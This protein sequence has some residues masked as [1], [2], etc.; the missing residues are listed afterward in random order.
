MENI[1]LESY[2][3]FKL[4]PNNSGKLYSNF[5]SNNKRSSITR[6]YYIISVENIFLTY[7]HL[8]I[9]EQCLYMLYTQNKLKNG[10][11]T[12]NIK[13]SDLAKKFKTDITKSATDTIKRLCEMQEVTI[14]I[15]V[16]DK[17]DKQMNIVE[18]IDTGVS[19]KYADLP[20]EINIRLNAEFVKLYRCAYLDKI[21]YL[22][23]FSAEQGSFVRY[24]MQH[25]LDGGIKASAI[26]DKMGVFEYIPFSRKKRFEQEISNLNF[27]YKN[28]KFQVKDGFVVQ[29]SGAK[30][31]SENQN[32][33]V[34]LFGIIYEQI[35]K[36][37]TKNIV[38]NDENLARYYERF[39]RFDKPQSFFKI[40]SNL[41]LMLNQSLHQENATIT[42]FSHFF[43]SVVCKNDN[44]FVVFLELNQKGFEYIISRR[45]NLDLW[46]IGSADYGLTPYNSEPA[47]LIN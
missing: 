42:Y 7:S 38:L 22:S 17:V 1:F 18:F 16:K 33:Q 31:V 14:S 36:N 6:C 12:L 23:D 27:Y 21:E 37:Y 44:G 26:L 3:I 45:A 11:F 5:I 4:Y 41:E 46:D 2:D 10:D 29:E 20:E 39:D 40:L 8:L 25:D 47:R 32:A 19:E 43:D 30:R 15:I 28:E 24:F 9:Y 35:L 13:K 34:M